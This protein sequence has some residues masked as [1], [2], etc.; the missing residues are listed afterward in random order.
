MD[1][2]TKRQRMVLNFINRH[3]RKRG[4]PPTIR[5]IAENL[6]IRWTH[7]IERHLLALEKKGYIVRA[8]DKSR[9]IELT[10]RTVGI[11]VPIV[12]KSADGGFVLLNGIAKR[13]IV[14]DPSITRDE[15]SFLVRVDKVDGGDLE[16]AIGDYVLV[17]RRATFRS[18]DI[19]AV[20]IAGEGVVV[21]RVAA[22]DKSSFTRD[23]ILKNEEVIG[24]VTAVIRLLG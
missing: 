18:G 23:I 13:Y 12:E 2:L 4:Y 1:N 3:L 19:V 24:K 5:E 8:R 20:F 21:Q 15:Q 14:L 7:G 11:P 10:T 6:G 17:V 22:R 9:G 16:I